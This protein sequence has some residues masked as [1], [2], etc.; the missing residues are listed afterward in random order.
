MHGRSYNSID[1][2]ATL[3]IL[4]GGLG[5]ITIILGLTHQ[6]NHKILSFSTILLLLPSIICI[7]YVA[8]G[9]EL[10]ANLILIFSLSIPLLVASIAPPFN[11][12]EVAYTLSLPKH[13]LNEGYFPYI[14]NY[15]FYSLFPLYA[16]AINTAIYST[17]GYIG[18]HI[19]GSLSYLLMGVALY[20]IARSIGLDSNYSIITTISILALKANYY[21]APTSKIDNFLALC[22]LTTLCMYLLPENSIR[23]TKRKYILG[24]ILIAISIGLKYSAIYTLPT[25][26]FI[27][28]YTAYEKTKSHKFIIRNLMFMILA[29]VSIN[30]PW[31][32]RNWI[33]TGNPVFPIMN[34]IIGDTLNYPFEKYHANLVYELQNGI[35]AYSRRGT[36]DIF[37]FL[38]ILSNESTLLPYYL[39]PFSLFY[40]YV[41]NRRLF[42]FFSITLVNFIIYIYFG[43][44]EIRFIT[45]LNSL[46]IILNLNF[47]FKII[48]LIKIK[49]FY[50]KIIILIA[51]FIILI[52]CSLAIVQAYKA[53]LKCIN[54]SVDKMLD[55]GINHAP[56]GTVAKYLNDIMGPSDI[57]AIN[58]QPF[59]YLKGNYVL[60][61]PWS[62]YGNLK[63]T[64]D[65]QIYLNK[66]KAIGVT[67]IAWT[68]FGGVIQFNKNFQDIKSYYFM[69]DEIIAQLQLGGK[70][71][72]INELS[73]TKIFLIN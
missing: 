21:L 1:A 45:V 34:N 66:L 19:F 46:L 30:I 35:I 54:L 32:F 31:L 72:L 49:E 18:I 6:I 73:G 70:I 50:K 27:F 16:D 17:F 43:P 51:T 71:K 11:W 29:I 44:W 62:E 10:K 36:D 47:L 68:N 64:D 38:R 56:Y 12:D 42:Y 22:L 9:F 55:C 8:R 59:F 14:K 58:T 28:I 53:P 41:K 24:S 37:V 20:L 26:I 63:Y 65:P 25:V 3:I 15:N 2:L 69:T 57:V 5:F 61:H 60:V 4:I 33:E 67:Y 48:Q 52:N 13:Y 23:T 39:T 40:Y 7:F